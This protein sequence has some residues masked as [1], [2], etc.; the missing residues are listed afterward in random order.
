[1]NE[2][3]LSRFSNALLKIHGLKIVCIRPLR[4]GLPPADVQEMK[5]DDK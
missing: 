4:R 3:E 5:S 2:E 1:M